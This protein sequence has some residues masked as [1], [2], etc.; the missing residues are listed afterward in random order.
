MKHE[1]EFSEV[2]DM[3]QKGRLMIEIREEK[4]RVERKREEEKGKVE[5]L[6]KA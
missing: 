3:Q 2:K 4:E 6:S 5:M 1:R